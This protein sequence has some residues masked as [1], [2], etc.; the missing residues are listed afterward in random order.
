MKVNFVY[1]YVFVNVIEN[2]G[3]SVSLDL[4]EGF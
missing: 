4:V 3:I 2:I 1:M